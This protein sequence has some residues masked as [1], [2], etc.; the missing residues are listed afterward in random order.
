[1]GLLLPFSRHLGVPSTNVPIFLGSR[2][3]AILSITTLVT[4]MHPRINPPMT[5]S[6]R[7]SIQPCQDF[8]ILSNSL[9]FPSSSF[10]QIRNIYVYIIC[11]LFESHMYGFN[12]S[13][14]NVFWSAP[15]H[16]NR[17]CCCGL[18]CFALPSN[19]LL[20]FLQYT[21]I[22][23]IHTYKHTNIHTYTHTHIH[24]YKHTNIQTLHCITLH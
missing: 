3:T 20:Y 16:A 21:Y 8:V 14:Q 17:L 7:S 2:S 24:T 10:G 1:M 22:H 15:S 4:R 5:G 23:Y 11:I 18:C 6:T 9:T 13:D 19:Y 12:M